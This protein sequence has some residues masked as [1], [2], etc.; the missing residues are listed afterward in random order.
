M[1]L[2]FKKSFYRIMVFDTLKEQFIQFFPTLV[3]MDKLL[4]LFDYF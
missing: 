2:A 4:L 1:V 3:K